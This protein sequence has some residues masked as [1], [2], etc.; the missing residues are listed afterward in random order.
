MPSIFRRQPT[1][2]LNAGSLVSWRTGDAR[3]AIANGFFEAAGG[4]LGLA[5]IASGA[6]A[7]TPRLAYRA[8]T[9]SIASTASVFAPSVRPRV[10]LPTVGSAAAVSAPELRAMVALPTVG[11][12]ANVFAPTV[13]PVGGGAQ[14]LTLASI[15]GA[16]AVF[17]PQL[18]ARVSL[19]SLGSTA[20]VFAPNT[21]GVVSLPTLTSSA[22]T[23]PPVLVPEFSVLVPTLGSSAATFGPITVAT[24]GPPEPTDPPLV[25]RW[26]DTSIGRLLTVI[27]LDLYAV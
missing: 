26:K 4:G 15:G 23:S 7:N 13:T 22:T 6:T 20:N 17:A 5:F 1:E 2:R 16:S 11:S 3:A 9:P 8:V 12:G 25:R 19:P 21:R 14:S 24:T 18:R 27:G 10:T